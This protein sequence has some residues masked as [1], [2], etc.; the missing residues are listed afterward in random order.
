MSGSKDKTI[1][2]WDKITGKVI[3]NL[4]GHTYDVWSVSFSP[5]HDGNYI[6]SGS[7]DKTVK[8]WSTATG[9]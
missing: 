9:E 8:I 3:K 4:E 1:K 2:I 5:D 7:Y 6:V